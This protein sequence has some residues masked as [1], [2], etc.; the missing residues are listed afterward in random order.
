[1]E[2]F[3]DAKKLWPDAGPYP[4]FLVLLGEH[5]AYRAFA[6]AHRDL[7]AE[8]GEQLGAVPPRWL[9]S[10]VQGIHHP[11]DEGRMDLLREAARAQFRGVGPFTV[12]LGPTWPGITAVTV[13][14]YPEAGMAELNRRARAA[15]ESVPGIVLR[16]A[17]SRFWAHSTIAY[18]RADFDSRKLNRAL[19]SLRPERVEVTVDR[20]HLVDQ[21]QDPQRGTYTWDIVEEFTLTD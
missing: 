13:A 18:A 8:Y 4:H 9:H 12:Q 2:N 20:V 16:P 15:A 14:M 5:P 11:V 7:L 3:F 19:R 21:H 1:M 6:D 17:E 10:T